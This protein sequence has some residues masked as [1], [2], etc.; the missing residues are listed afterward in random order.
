MV[1]TR[2]KAIIQFF[3]DYIKWITTT[4]TPPPFLSFCLFLSAEIVQESDDSDS[5]ER[6]NFD[7]SLPTRHQVRNGFKMAP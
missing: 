7:Q 2:R 5:H 4:F 1:T 3:C 6:V